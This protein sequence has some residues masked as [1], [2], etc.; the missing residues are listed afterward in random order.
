M[1]PESQRESNFCP[2]IIG[3][4]YGQG[5]NSNAPI[6]N[7]MAPSVCFRMRTKPCQ[8]KWRVQ[9]F[10]LP[11]LSLLIGEKVGSFS[12]STRKCPSRRWNKDKIVSCY[13]SVNIE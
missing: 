8:S 1:R 9:V 5:D 2:E 7:L 13:N 12:C 3:K 4:T 11:N 10:H 6:K